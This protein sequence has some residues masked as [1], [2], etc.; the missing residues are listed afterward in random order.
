[1]VENAYRGEKCGKLQKVRLVVSLTVQVG[2]FI[3]NGLQRE[4]YGMH[5]K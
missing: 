1:M 2:S 5:G 4:L 3:T